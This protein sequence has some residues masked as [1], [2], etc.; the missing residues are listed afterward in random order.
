MAKKSPQP[1]SYLRLRAVQSLEQLAAQ[2]GIAAAQA[3]SLQQALLRQEQIGPPPELETQKR[4]EEKKRLSNLIAD[5]NGL[6]QFANQAQIDIFDVILAL[7]RP[8]E[9]LGDPLIFDPKAI[10]EMDDFLEGIGKFLPKRNRPILPAGNLL[11]VN[12]YLAKTIA[13]EVQLTFGLYLGENKDLLKFPL[14][15]AMGNYLEKLEDVLFLVSRWVN[16]TLNKREYLWSEPEAAPKT[17]PGSP[18]GTPPAN[19]PQNPPA[20]PPQTPGP[21]SPPPRA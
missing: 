4:E 11:S 5:V 2:I 15:K 16:L 3:Q 9:E 14:V 1:D 12:L 18:S 8:P 19:Q 17:Q 7:N 21:G 10:Q 20:N 6:L 13:K